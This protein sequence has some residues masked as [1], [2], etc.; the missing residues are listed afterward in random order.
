MSLPPPPSPALPLPLPPPPPLCDVTLCLTLVSSPPAPLSFS[1]KYRKSPFGFPLHDSPSSF[2]SPPS[3]SLTSLCLYPVL[4]LLVSFSLSFSSLSLPLPSPSPP[5]LLPL[6]PILQSPLALQWPPPPAGSRYSRATTAARSS[7]IQTPSWPSAAVRLTRLPAQSAGSAQTTSHRALRGVHYT[8]AS[9]QTVPAVTTRDAC[10]RRRFCRPVRLHHRRLPGHRRLRRRRPNLTRSG[11]S[12]M[13]RPARRLSA[14]GVPRRLTVRS[15]PR[16]CLHRLARPRSLRRHRRRHRT[17]RLS[18][19]N[20]S[21]PSCPMHLIHPRPT[22]STSRY[23]P[24]AQWSPLPCA[25]V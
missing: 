3:L 11:R 23:L 22:C 17:R 10:S 16:G 24:V 1:R 5:P 13:R 15:H 4:S 19:S 14:G 2:S 6:L 9:D 21:K 20:G 25:C 18:C 8:R 12:H 7:A